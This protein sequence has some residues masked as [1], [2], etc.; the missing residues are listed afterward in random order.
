MP[1]NKIFAV[2]GLGAFGLEICRTLSEKGLSVIA[3]DNQA[4]PIERI[5]NQVTRAILVDATDE[6]SF[7]RAGLDDVDIAIVA[8]GDNLET[9]ILTTALLKRIGVPYVYARAV[10]DLHEA[11]LKQVG[12]DNVANIQK[13]QGRYLAMKLIAPD[14]L[15]RIPLS[16]NISIAEVVVPDSFVGESLG[17]LQLRQKLHINVVCIKRFELSIDEVGNPQKQETVLFPEASDILKESDILMV[18]GRDEDI[19]NLRSD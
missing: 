15:D 7:S 14:I 5:K 16:D 4:E 9:S 18:V 6:D 1:Q 11:V 19:N 17:D 3:V 13:A 2:I 8:I 12:A 10:N